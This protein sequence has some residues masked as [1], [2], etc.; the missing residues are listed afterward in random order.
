MINE[1][2]LERRKMTQ[3]LKDFE[4]NLPSDLPQISPTLAQTA[5]NALILR[6]IRQKQNQNR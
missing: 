2:D 1:Q 6:D 4:K 3:T 5:K